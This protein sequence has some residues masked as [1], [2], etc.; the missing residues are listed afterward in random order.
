VRHRISEFVKKKADEL[1]LEKS[2][3][4]TRCEAEVYTVIRFW[5]SLKPADVPEDE[6]ACSFLCQG[7]FL[8]RIA[9]ESEYP[10]EG[11]VVIKIDAL[12][13]F[14][15]RFGQPRFDSIPFKDVMLSYYFRAAEYF[16][17]K[18]KYRKFF[19]TLINEAERVY[20][21]GM[22][23]FKSYVNQNLMTDS[24]DEYSDLEKPVFVRGL[25]EELAKKI[26]DQ[27][28][29]IGTLETR[30]KLNEVK[31]AMTEAELQK[32]KQKAEKREKYAE[33]QRRRKR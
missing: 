6:W 18:K 7:S 16:V 21:E 27:Q 31:L 10:L 12:Y 26:Q 1:Y 13:E 9:R 32:Y 25:Q 20:Q 8:N 23:N 30:A 29:E 24:I 5:R 33:K 28:I 11:N 4:R 19:G 2:D 22:D 3:L 15:R 17:D 14:L